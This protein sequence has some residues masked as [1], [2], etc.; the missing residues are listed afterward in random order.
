MLSLL[1]LVHLDEFRCRLRGSPT[2]L[3]TRIAVQIDLI[4]QGFSDF[5]PPSVVFERLIHS[6]LL[7]LT[8]QLVSAMLS[9]VEGRIMALIIEVVSLMGIKGCL[10][11]LIASPKG[12]GWCVKR[13]VFGVRVLVLVVEIKNC[14]VDVTELIVPHGL[15]VGVTSS[16]LVCF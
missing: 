15:L 12:V 5:E 11:L 14:I 4:T 3:L 9:Q 8:L 2:A 13:L 16:D 6:L 1:A 7:L 10:V